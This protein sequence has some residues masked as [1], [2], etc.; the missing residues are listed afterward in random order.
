M[1][2]CGVVSC[3]SEN[4]QQ[5]ALQPSRAHLERIA[6]ASGRART[7]GKPLLVNVA[8]CAIVSPRWRTISVNEARFPREL[9]VPDIRPG[10]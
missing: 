10:Y 3:G 8:W 1:R 4:A 7:A 9:P 2:D 5:H 6:R